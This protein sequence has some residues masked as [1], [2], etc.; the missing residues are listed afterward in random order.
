MPSHDPGRKRGSWR[1]QRPNAAKRAAK[2]AALRREST[3]TEK[4]EFDR[5]TLE[6][7]SPLDES[8]G[9]INNKLEKM[10]AMYSAVLL[11]NAPCTIM[12]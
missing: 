8:G 1:V 10:A 9:S 3:N 11:P 2:R 6:Q 7:R 5:Q 4:E 12:L